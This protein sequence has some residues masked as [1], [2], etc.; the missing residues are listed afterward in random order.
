[1]VF[2]WSEFMRNSKNNRVKCYNCG[3]AGGNVNKVLKYLHSKCL[4]YNPDYVVIMFGVN[5]ILRQLY[6]LVDGVSVKERA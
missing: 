4:I 3:V 6:V 5:D 2:V 1:M